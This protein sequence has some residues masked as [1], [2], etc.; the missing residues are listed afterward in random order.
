MTR[1][2]DLDP[3]PVIL[4]QKLCCMA[5]PC[6]QD[7]GGIMPASDGHVL[8]N[9]YDEKH[10]S[11]F[12]NARADYVGLLPVNPEAAILELG[13]GNGATGRL[14]LLE[15]KAGRYVGIEFFA[16]MADEAAK[17]LTT[18]H[19]EDVEHFDLPYHSNTFD[20]LILS[21]VLEHLVNPGAVL[22]RLVATLKPGALI[23]ASSPNISHWRNV[24]SLARGRFRYT[25]SGMMDRTHLHWFTPESFRS[26]FEDAGVVVDWL[27]PLNRLRR[28]E[29][30][31]G[32]VLPPLAPLMYF[33]IDLH[34]HF[35]P[36]RLS[37]GAIRPGVGS[38]RA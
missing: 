3:C 38:V 23:F 9:A 17:V 10:T 34:G 24:L 28:L 26:L 22:R 2:I 25:E 33:Q 1:S 27:A 12:G 29:R 14:A 31:I 5:V 11:Y 37:S 35:D 16:P 6:S 36:S 21:E 32:K 13:C 30:F 4:F 18:V 20:A 19:C 7:R 15:R 8:Q